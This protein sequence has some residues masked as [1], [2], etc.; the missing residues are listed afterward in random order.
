[1]VQSRVES[2]IHSV[3]EVI[4]GAAVGTLLALIMFQVWS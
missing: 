2:G 3:P 4:Y 1:V